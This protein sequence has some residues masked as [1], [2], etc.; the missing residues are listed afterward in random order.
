VDV[1]L[2]AI[3]LSEAGDVLLADNGGRVDE[4][5]IGDLVALEAQRA[6]LAGIVIWGLH[7]DSAELCEIGIPVFSLG[8][9]PCGPLSV[10]DRDPA[11][12]LSARVGEWTAKSTD[13]IV[14]DDDGIVVF[15]LSHLAQIAEAAR[16]IKTTEIEHARLMR[17]GE[18]FRSQ[19]RFGDFLGGRAKDPSLTFRRHLR[20]A[21]GSIEE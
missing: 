2:E 4:A 17:N 9:N 12:L 11:A 8:C 15:P 3:E 14:A 21:G 13:V 16:K 7:R 10:H 18:S 20:G 5:C 6:G 19:V 1:F